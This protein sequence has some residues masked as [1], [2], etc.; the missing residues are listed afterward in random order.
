MSFEERY[1]F[2]TVANGLKVDVGSRLLDFLIS[3]LKRF[4]QRC[5]RLFLVP[6]HGERAGFVVDHGAG[7]GPEHFGGVTAEF[8]DDD[9]GLEEERVGIFS[10]VLVD[11]FLCAGL[12]ALG[13]A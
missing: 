8:A 2:L 9:C 4:V 5:Q 3:P 1:E 7:V 11:Q 13:S 6:V 10:G 12:K